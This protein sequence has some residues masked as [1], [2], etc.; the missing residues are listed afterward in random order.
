MKYFE[1]IAVSRLRSFVKVVD[2]PIPANTVYFRRMRN[3]GYKYYEMTLKNKPI[4]EFFYDP[5]KKRAYSTSVSEKFRGMGLGKKM[6]GE[7]LKKEKYMEPGGFQT[8]EA[9]KMWK[10]L[11]KKYP[12]LEKGVIYP[13]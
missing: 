7:V 6:Y 11:R 13:K 4:G 1:K 9:K 8:D 2:K 3:K 12:N 10:Y 5:K